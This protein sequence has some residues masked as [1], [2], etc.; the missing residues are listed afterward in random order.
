[1][2]TPTA[3]DLTEA[4]QSACHLYPTSD[5]E[6]A[7]EFCAKV[8]P[9]FCAADNDRLLKVGRSIR[10]LVDMHKNDD[11]HDFDDDKLAA[12]LAL[13]V[14][15]CELLMSGTV[16][17][18]KVT[19]GKTGIQIS[20][21]TLGCMRFQQAWGP[22]IKNMNM[23]NADC[24]DNLVA[25]LKRAILEFGIN[26]IETARGYGSS[27]LQLGVALK[28]LLKTTSIN[29]D[30]LII[31]TKLGPMKDPKD[32]RKALE[33]SFEKL[34]VD[35]LDLFGFHGVNLPIQVKWIF[36]DKDNGDVE[37][38][39]SVIQEYVNAGKIRHVGFSTHGPTD[40][41]LDCINKDVFS[42]VNLHYHFIGSYTASGG[43]HDGEGNRD[44]I[45]LLNE[46]NMGVFIISPY[47]KGGALY[48]P[49]R[50][51]RKLTL[52]E[53][54]P[55]SFESLRIFNHHHLFPF[56]HIHTF[57]NGAARPSDLD[58][59]A[60]AAH[61]HATQNDKVVSKL[62]L[63]HQRLL[64]AREKALG[65]HWADTWWK[66]LTKANDNQHLVEHNQMIWLYNCLHAFGLYHFAK[67]RYK[68]FEDNAKNWD[69]SKTV[70]ENLDRMLV[71]WGFVPGLPLKPEV[72][73]S[74]D[75]VNVPDDNKERVREAE[76]FVYEWLASKRKSAV[77]TATNGEGDG[78]NS[79][80][81][82]NGDKAAVEE[83]RIPKDWEDAYD[84]R[85]WEDFPNRIRRV[86]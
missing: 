23:V 59:A 64:D 35:Y 28:Q 27:E 56:L 10:N 44:C 30:D 82:Q 26:H 80:A 79:E 32:F 4:A 17:V 13:V 49:S 53:M 72:D 52:P 22:H 24:Q 71:G 14:Q 69:D 48:V 25:I 61:L 18:P 77:S 70:Q 12:S 15:E 41:I 36:G 6:L 16:K 68:A 65:K 21:V 43:G 54:E 55:M 51:L 2:A 11:D 63:V 75:M 66:G 57:T 40:F 67:S 62:Q 39:Y 38:C 85:T 42:Y 37:T 33:T 31:Q 29:R 76:A 58:Q 19:F 7:L 81:K 5:V 46:K 73:Y 84:M 34:G 83:R 78:K 50:K 20:V 9:S 60:V 74:S 8:V 47:D 1:M 86:D 3:L 45:R